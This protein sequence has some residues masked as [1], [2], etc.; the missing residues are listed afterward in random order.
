MRFFLCFTTLLTLFS[1]AHAALIPTLLDSIQTDYSTAYSTHY[2]I[3]TGS[4][5]G[6]SG[7]IANTPVDKEV[8]ENWQAHIRGP[9]SNAIA[10]PATAIGG[11]PQCYAAMPF[12]LGLQWIADLHPD[13]YTAQWLG[14]WAN[15]AFRITTLVAPHQWLLTEALGAGR[16]TQGNAHWHPLNSHR[17]KRGVSGHAAY[18]AIPFLS[19]ATLMETPWK[20]NA[21]YI[22][23]T[24]PAFARVNDDKHY[25]SQALLGWGLTYISSEVV[26]HSQESLRWKLVPLKDGLALVYT[27]KYN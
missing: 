20:R 15:H 14:L 21:F 22:L 4:L 5:V 3:Q 19:A 25:F 11:V 26:I 6:V 12:Y 24:L 8:R 18:G 10:S 17:R 1:A 9:L 2:F 23:S 7:L 13:Y 27:Y 16:P